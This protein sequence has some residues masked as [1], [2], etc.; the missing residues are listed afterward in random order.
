[1]L[2]LPYGKRKITLGIVAAMLTPGRT[3]VTKRN[4]GGRLVRPAYSLAAW[5]FGIGLWQIVAWVVTAARGVPFPTPLE[6]ALGLWNLLG[7]SPFLDHSIYHHVSVSLMRWMEGFCLGL[8]G[9]LVYALVAGWAP[10]LRNVTMPTVEVLQL[11]PGL[12]WIPVAILLFGLNH[13]AT[14]ALIA[15]TAFPAVAIA[16]VMGVRSVDMRYVR[17]GRMCGAGPVTL[18]ATVFLPGA[19]PHILSG[20]RIALGAAW[21]VLVAAEMIV[22]SGDGLGYAVIQSRWTMDYVSAFVCIAIIAALGLGLER[23]VL[24][25]LERR[26]VGCWEVRDEH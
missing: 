13:T 3:D 2:N 6:C 19:L 22:G 5:V 7:G 24:T 10:S 14:V 1:M 20:L 15:L 8:S 18:F 4:G 25:P 9:G 11:I 26:T 23:L 17:A 16:G 21:R 12:A